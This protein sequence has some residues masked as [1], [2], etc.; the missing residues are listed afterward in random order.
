M[1]LLAR[2]YLEVMAAYRKCV[3]PV[4]CVKIGKG[5]YSSTTLS[6]KLYLVAVLVRLRWCRGSVLAF[7][8]QVCGF[9]PRRGR[10]IFRAKKSSAHLPSEGK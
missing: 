7:S 8:T 9:K 6:L 4:V 5:M 10:R 2:D 3:I 1:N